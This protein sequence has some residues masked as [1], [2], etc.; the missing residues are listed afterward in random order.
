MKNKKINII[1]A[2]YFLLAF[3]LI[4]QALI[5]VFKLGHIVSYQHRIAKLEQKKQELVKQQQEIELELGK[6][7][8]LS[9][10]QA[11]LDEEYIDIQSPIRLTIDDSVALK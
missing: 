10:R 3:V 4:T 2:Y 5:T 6:I 1:K 11:E 7:T 8:A 9:L